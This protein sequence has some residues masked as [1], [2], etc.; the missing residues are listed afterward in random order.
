MASN[1]DIISALRL[2]NTSG[3][4]PVK[5]Y[6]LVDEFSSA[7]K[8]VAFLEKNSKQKPWNIEEAQK[9]LDK[10]NSLGVSIVLYSD[11]TYPFNLRGDKNAPPLLYVKG[12][13]S[14]LTSF[15]KSIGI[16]G[17]R[18]ASP[19]GCKTAAKLAKELCD[20][21]V[22]V[23]SGMARG[24]DTSAHKGAMYGLN[25]TGKTIAVLGTGVDI[26]YKGE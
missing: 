17:G 8:A 15:E 20:N 7:E 13:V 6:Q 10:A 18:S 9:E 16:V 12:D 5:F 14:T 11:E 24:I 26:I 25:Q 23:I 2:I 21:N 3:I 4:G 1:K 22:C 19:I